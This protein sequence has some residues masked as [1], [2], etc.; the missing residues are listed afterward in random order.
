MS[1]EHVN[2]AIV[3]V[4][5]WI[6]QLVFESLARTTLNYYRIQEYKTYEW[7]GISIIYRF[8]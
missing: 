1:S 6:V 2:K 7:P 3:T 4:K 8:K 5:V